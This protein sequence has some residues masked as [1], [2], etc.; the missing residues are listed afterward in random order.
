M[1]IHV[2]VVAPFLVTKCALGDTA[3]VGCLRSLTPLKLDVLIPKGTIFRALKYTKK[4]T[5]VFIGKTNSVLW[6][7]NEEVQ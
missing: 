6:I 3:D 5:L 1:Y 2:R 4:S 7:S